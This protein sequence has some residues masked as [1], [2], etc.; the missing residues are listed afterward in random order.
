MNN[1]LIKKIRSD[2]EKNNLDGLFI[3]NS[4]IHLN[5]NTNLLLKPVFQII[6][7]DSTFCYLII[8]KK[9]MAL[10]TDKRYLLQAKK[11]F[12]KSNIRIYEYSYKNINLYLNDNFQYGSILG[13]D[14]KRI[15]LNKFKEIK[16]NIFESSSTLLPI[17][18]TF[19]NLNKN[20]KPNFDKS[21]TFS[22][23]KTHTP[24]TLDKNINYIKSRI[25][26]DAI[27]IWDNAHIAYL[28]NIRSFEL[29]NSTK[30][31]AGLLILKKG[32]HVI[33]SDNPLIKKITK[34]NDNFLINSYSNFLKKI[35]SLKIK[36]LEVDFDKINLDIFQS[37]RFL[38]IDVFD[39]TVDLSNYISIKTQKEYK[40]INKAHFE[41]GLA[42]TKFL[43]FF[44]N[45][46]ISSYDEYSLSL[47]LENFRKERVN[48]F[49]NSFDYISAFDGNASKIHY[50]PLKTKS[51][52]AKNCII[53]LIDSGAHYLEGTTD[54]T[55]VIG[56]KNISITIKNAYTSILKSLIH[57]DL[58]S[59]NYPLPANKLDFQIRNKLI[60]NKITYGHG[61]GHG[62]GYFN[63][64]HERPPVISPL[65]HDYIKGNQFFS[66][67]PGYYVDDKFGLRI[68]N[69]YFS[70]LKNNKIVLENSTL[71]PY[72]LKMINVNLLKSKEIKF[73]N[74]YH[75]KIYYLYEDYLSDVE[76]KHFMSF[77]II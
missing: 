7:F 67:E 71:V 48:F 1:N 50:K 31:F 49:R 22:L 32:K 28:L 59:F 45:N 6:K 65:S 73:I 4:D 25:K 44:K 56:L 42:M 9:N 36:K 35:K 18:N 62:V 40:N 33:I 41:D 64:V 69:L 20:L 61:T 39:S 30:P 58:K 75:Y 2:L 14:P 70:K 21:L 17:N 57:I 23:P 29:D 76:K 34:F 8:L 52:K 72:D 74:N 53:Y 38:S 60:L 13:V 68:E 46:N 19:F 37:L 10:F 16:T 15:S 5:E 11:Q 27:L 47:V 24:R 43:L 26:T 51:L 54:V 12:S 55:R 66:I 3:T 63:D 77:F